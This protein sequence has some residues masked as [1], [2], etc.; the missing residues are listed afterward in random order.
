[1][2]LTEAISG[3]IYQALAGWVG[4]RVSSLLAPPAPRPLPS[5]PLGQGPELILGAYQLASSAS[6]AVSLFGADSRPGWMGDAEWQ[7]ARWA[8]ILPA[9]MAVVGQLLG[10]AAQLGAAPGIED[11]LALVLAG[12]GTLPLRDDLR[13]QTLLRSVALGIPPNLSDPAWEGLS[14]EDLARASTSPSNPIL[15][16]EAMQDLWSRAQ[17]DPTGWDLPAMQA[18]LSAHDPSK[19]NGGTVQDYYQAAK[20]SWTDYPSLPVSVELEGGQATLLVDGI[21]VS[22]TS[23]S[24]TDPGQSWLPV[25]SPP[26]LPA[27]PAE[28]AAHLPAQSPS[29]GPSHEGTR[30]GLGPEAAGIPILPAILAAY[31]LARFMRGGAD[32]E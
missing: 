3:A 12:R 24:A 18:L 21:P 10:R 27:P 8:R 4:S 16:L 25:S 13:A 32:G 5:R 6:L 15:T 14:P 20:P 9:W 1:M 22:E 17:A 28:T 29:A 30:W 2:A 23:T 11:Y 19:G 7:A 26:T 31:L